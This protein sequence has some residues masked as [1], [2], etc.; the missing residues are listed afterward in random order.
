M[1]NSIVTLLLIFT[2]SVLQAQ[3]NTGDS[4]LNA[5]LIQIDANASVDFGF[6][7]SDVSTTY[8]VPETKINNWSVNLGMKAG[9]I[10][11]ALELARILK[12]KPEEVVKIYTSN[13]QKGWGAIAKDLGIKP[14]SPE[15]HALKGGADKNA[16]KGKGN[17]KGK[18]GGAKGGKKN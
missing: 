9:D 18:N 14:G 8:G 10:Y 17:S 1:R 3:Y 16:A 15:F 6:F 13:K 4:Q 11:F 2:F 12:K 5:S 7:K